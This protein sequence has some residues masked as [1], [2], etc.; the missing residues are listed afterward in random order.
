M[1]RFAGESVAPK[2]TVT[3]V[4][5]EF[6]PAAVAVMV[7]V[8]C[9]KPFKFDCR[10]GVVCPALKET[11][12]REVTAFV[13][14]LLVRLITRPD[15]PGAGAAK[16]TG[17]VTLSPGPKVMVA[18]TMMSTERVTV[19]AA[20]ASVKPAAV[21]RMVVVPAATPVTGTVT[22]VAPAAM[23]ALEVTVAAAMLLELKVTTKPPTGAG[24]DKVKVRF[25]V[26]VPFTD[27]VSGVKAMVAV[28][29][30]ACVAEV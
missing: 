17:Y 22:V 3:R 4:L 1:V 14:S 7:V 18:G 2:P 20:V 28:T 15:G 12:P 30:T 8:P 16:V 6:R 26:S 13:A 25:F 19:T 21:A 5:A 24:P 11:L 10:V 29:W 9:T 27:N 23:V